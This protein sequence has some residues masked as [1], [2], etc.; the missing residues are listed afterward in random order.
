MKD[1]RLPIAWI[2]ALE[3]Q[4][5]PINNFEVD[6]SSEFVLLSSGF[7]NERDLLVQREATKFSLCRVDNLKSVWKGIMMPSSLIIKPGDANS[8]LLANLNTSI[9]PHSNIVYL[10]SISNI[11]FFGP[12]FLLLL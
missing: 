9:F 6:Q 7:G 8:S 11:T 2:A 3:T 12:Y 5:S 4:L 1:E 10:L